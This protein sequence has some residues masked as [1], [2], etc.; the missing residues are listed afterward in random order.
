MKVI[1]KL[2][3]HEIGL[4]GS[5]P[6]RGEYVAFETNAYEVSIFPSWGGRT[7]IEF[8]GVLLGPPHQRNEADFTRGQDRLANPKLTLPSRGPA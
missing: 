4:L 7:D 5:Q 1:L 8:K 3:P 6:D 2:E